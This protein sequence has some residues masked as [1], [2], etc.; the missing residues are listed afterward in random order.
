MEFSLSPF[1]LLTSLHPCYKLKANMY[2]GLNED[3]D[4]FGSGIS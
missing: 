1:S 4:F 2:P 3:L